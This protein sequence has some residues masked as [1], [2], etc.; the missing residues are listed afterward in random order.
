[1]SIWTITKLFVQGAVYMIVAVATG[2]LATLTINHLTGSE[3]VRTSWLVTAFALG[4]IVGMMWSRHCYR[5][6]YR[7]AKQ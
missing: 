5:S 2:V 6:A 1:M 7:K 4:G 3:T